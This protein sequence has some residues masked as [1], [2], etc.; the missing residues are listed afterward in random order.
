MSEMETILQPFTL[1]T[2][3][4]CL[5]L[6]EH[7]EKHGKTL[8]DVRGF[9]ERRPKVPKVRVASYFT[10]R[11]CPKCGRPMRLYTVNTGVEDQVGKDPATGKPYRTM[12]FCGTSCSGKG[13]WYEEY[14]T[15]TV[16]E[17]LEK[18]RRKRR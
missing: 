3:Q 18:L 11:P 2:I 9:L 8:D 5:I 13:C 1:K 6:Y 7:L 15:L 10:H 4:E 16:E 14:S 12:W 17:Q